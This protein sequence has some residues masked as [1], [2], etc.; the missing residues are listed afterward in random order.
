MVD[1]KGGPAKQKKKIGAL[2]LAAAVCVLLQGCGFPGSPEE[3]MGPEVEGQSG[4][5]T[6]LLLGPGPEEEGLPG[7]EWSVLEM[8]RRQGEDG[9]GEDA[10]LTVYIPEEAAVFRAPDAEEMTGET[11]EAG[12]YRQVEMAGNPLWFSCGEIWLYGEDLYPVVD[13]TAMDITLTDAIVEERLADLKETF[14]SGQ[15]WNHMGQELEGGEPSPF[16]VTDEPCEHSCYDELYCNHY[17]GSML[18]I[19]PFD[20]LTQCLGFACLL[21]DQIFDSD[22]MLYLLPDRAPLRV[23]D[24]I[25]LR[26]Y[27]HSVIVC[28]VDEDGLQLAEVNAGYEDC[29]ISW[30]RAFSWEEW[31]EL[32]GWDVQYVVTRYPFYWDHGHWEPMEAVPAHWDGMANTDSY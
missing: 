12:S 22:A 8:M 32:Y 21:S 26:E 15:Y 30:E 23:G 3:S 25:R 13:G 4:S 16:S 7:A 14:P 17:Y 24:H 2:L 28:G 18:D 5:D 27:E 11:V 31:E 19:F 1:R 29:L 9:S 6:A 10:G 20:Y